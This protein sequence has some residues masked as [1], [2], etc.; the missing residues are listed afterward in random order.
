MTAHVRIHEPQDVAPV[1]QRWLTV[2][3]A[4]TYSS[5]SQ[6]TIRRLVEAGKLH[7]YRPVAGRLLVDRGQ[8]D[9]AI[10]ASKNGRTRSQQGRRGA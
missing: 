1:Q 10:M 7:A 9:A 6:K 4:A 3:G 2:A 5:L 8:L